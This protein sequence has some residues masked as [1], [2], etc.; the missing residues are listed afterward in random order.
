MAETRRSAT[1]E[2]GADTYRDLYKGFGFPLDELAGQCESF[3]ADTEDLYVR[4]LDTLFRRR[5]GISLDEAKRWDVPRLFR[6]SEWDIGFPGEL[7]L[8]ALEGT[9]AGL[10]IDL[11]AQENVHL[12]IEPRPTKSPRAFCAPIEVPG[13][14]MVGT[15]KL[16]G[17][18]HVVGAKVAG[19]API[20]GVWPSDHLAIVAEL[21]Y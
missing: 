12:D 16:G 7:M 1:R 9:L 10:G 11:R 15:P 20:G 19:N 8:P 18:G 3:L 5:V 21:R 17:V 2:L 14:V 6:A 4:A 13:R